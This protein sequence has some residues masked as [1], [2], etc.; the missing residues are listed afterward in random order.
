MEVNEQQRL[1]HVVIPQAYATVADFCNAVYAQFVVR[2]KCYINASG[3]T[4]GFVGVRVAHLFRYLCC[5]FVC[6]RHVFCV[7]NG[8]S[9]S[10]LSILAR[11][12]GVL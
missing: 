11:P 7:R 12:V 5:V 3:F 9:V 6:R 4:P 10:E 2:T 1:M 8:T